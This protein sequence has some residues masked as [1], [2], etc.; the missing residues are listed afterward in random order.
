[1][2]INRGGDMRQVIQYKTDK[3]RIQA[4]A[5]RE[6]CHAMIDANL[7]EIINVHDK[8]NAGLQSRDRKG[9]PTKDLEV[10]DMV[11]EIAIKDSLHAVAERD[12]LLKRW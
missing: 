11:M 12:F 1:M 9:L 6:R 3:E 10:L 7:A 2:T 8:I 4:G 5:E